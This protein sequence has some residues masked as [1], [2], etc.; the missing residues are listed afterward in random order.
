MQ[1]ISGDPQLTGALFWQY[2]LYQFA[3]CQI[4]VCIYT[5]AQA[6]YDMNKPADKISAPMTGGM[7][8]IPVG[9]LSSTYW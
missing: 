4:G 1:C 5:V 7:T 6:I 3:L 8:Q 9:L 2:D